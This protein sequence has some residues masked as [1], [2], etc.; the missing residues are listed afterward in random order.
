MKIL[1]TGGSGQVGFELRRS[2]ALFGQILAPSR[3][4]LDLADQKAVS[5][6]L[7][8]HRPGLIVNAAAYTAVDKAE[9]EPGLAERLNAELPAQLA[10]HA[11][12]HGIQLVHY[13]SDYVYPGTGSLPFS[14]EADTSPLN[15]YGRTKLAGDEAVIAA[16]CRHLIFRTSWVYSARGRNFMKTMLRLGRDRDGLDVVADQAGA[17]TPA[18]LIAEVT[19][20]AIARGNVAADMPSG[21]YHLATRGEVSWHG[22]AQAIFR[23]ANEQGEALRIRVENIRPVP[24]REYPTPAVRPLNSRLNLARLEAALGIELP[25]W[26]SQL[27]LTLEDYLQPSEWIQS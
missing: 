18:R 10:A 6:Y 12:E 9:T 7:Q 13:S 16:G 17:P 20:H 23:L 11:C 21:I 1:I 26:S 8:T 27:R 4:Q 15:V 2:L 22:F 19:A 5:D 25:D 14:E 24:T 3:Q